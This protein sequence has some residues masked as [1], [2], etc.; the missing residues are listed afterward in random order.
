MISKHILV[1][2]DD[3]SNCMI[4]AK[5]LASQGYQVDWTDNCQEALI[6][7]AGHEYGLALLD[8][9]MPAMDGVELYRQLREIR[10]EMI[11][12]FQTAFARIEVIYAAIEAGAERVLAKPVD[13]RELLPLVERL[14]GKPPEPHAE[15]IHSPAAVPS[16]F[17]EQATPQTIAEHEPAS[18]PQPPANPS[19]LEQLL[20]GYAAAGPAAIERRLKELEGEYRRQR[21]LQSCGMAA[22]IAGAILGAASGRKWLTVAS[23][24][25]GLAYLHTRT[26]QRRPMK[27]V[28][29][30]THRSLR[31]IELERFA[32]KALRRDFED[33]PPVGEN[34]LAAARAALLATQR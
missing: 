12:V 32:L 33:I 16:P 23:V 18:Q 24:V 26:G 13:S 20:A 8:Y 6:L 31:V 11:G 1:V 9:K 28:R 30:Q 14:V 34:P 29:P 10:P 21:D 4:L 15:E 19:A 2:D 17:A 25:G 5:L 22:A 3:R 27:A 7:V